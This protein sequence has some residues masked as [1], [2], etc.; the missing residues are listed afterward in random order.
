MS[1]FLGM[2]KLSYDKMIRDRGEDIFSTSDSEW[3][4]KQ[5]K[6]IVEKQSYDS[7]R[8]GEFSEARYDLKTEYCSHH[9][10]IGRGRKTKICLRCFLDEKLID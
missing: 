3:H 9:R 2:I 5:G 10:L 1:V 7:Y 6:I 8:Q 4:E